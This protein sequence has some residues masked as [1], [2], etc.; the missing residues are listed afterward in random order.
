MKRILA[1]F[2]LAFAFGSA[3]PASSKP[4]QVDDA[5]L[6]AAQRLLA[7]MPGDYYQVDPSSAMLQIENTG[8][9]VLDV[10]ESSE[11]KE[12]AIAGAVHIPI[13]DLAKAVGRLPEDKTTPILTYCKTGH[14]GAMA[15]T[16]L[17]MWGYSNVR[18]IRGGMDAWSKASLPLGKSV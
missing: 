7:P 16:I 18:N 1:I 13:R 8:P 12:G 4:P 15:M 11:L 14:R 2:G 10:R 3:Q 9:F 17:R 6:S 5:L